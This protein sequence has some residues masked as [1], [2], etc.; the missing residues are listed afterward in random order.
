MPSRQPISLSGKTLHHCFPQSHTFLET[1]TL[2]L[3]SLNT[4]TNLQHTITKPMTLLAKSNNQLLVLAVNYI[5][6]A[7]FPPG[8]L[9]YFRGSCCLIVICLTTCYKCYALFVN[10]FLVSCFG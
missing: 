7:F 8:T 1:F 6:V 2:F 10:L 9:L 3:K 5:I 4:K